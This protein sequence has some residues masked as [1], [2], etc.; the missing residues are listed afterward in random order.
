MKNFKRWLE[1]IF[2]KKP[3]TKANRE[4]YLFKGIATKIPRKENIAVLSDVAEVTLEREDEI[5]GVG[6]VLLSG[7]K[8]NENGFVFAGI[9]FLEMKDGYQL[10]EG[11]TLNAQFSTIGYNVNT[12]EATHDAYITLQNALLLNGEEINC[13]KD[14]IKTAILG[15]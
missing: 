7:I 5:I 14:N 4:Q 11:D 3:V 13:H 15:R 12:N 8:E 9:N 1:I 10:L 2:R 6:K